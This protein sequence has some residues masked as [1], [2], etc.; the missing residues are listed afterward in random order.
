M[1]PVSE[2]ITAQ[3]GPGAATS[4]TALS[5]TS[6]AATA[7]QETST[8]IM[9]GIAGI[10]SAIG[11]V[12]VSLYAARAKDKREERADA[13]AELRITVADLRNELTRCHEQHT[14]AERRI[15]LL[16]AEV[17]MLKKGVGSN[18]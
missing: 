9:L 16:E 2:E 10:V 1:K 15:I 8:G 4:A 5:I 6:L 3:I 7:A 13:I 14:G 11:S 17:A 12:L 18:G